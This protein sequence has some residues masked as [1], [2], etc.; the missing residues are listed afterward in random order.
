[1]A[2]FGSGTAAESDPELITQPQRQP[3]SQIDG[4]AATMKKGKTLGTL[5][6]PPPLRPRKQLAPLNP[7][8]GD[9]DE[10]D[11]S[12]RRNEKAV[13]LR[14]VVFDVDGTLW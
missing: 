2:G 7:S 1:M 5:N 11:C 13:R 8:R 6:N 4:E 3:F 14:G 12:G 10:M 9:G